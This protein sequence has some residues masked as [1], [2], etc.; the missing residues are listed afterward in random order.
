MMIC[1]P[2]SAQPNIWKLTMSGNYQYPI[3]EDGFVCQAGLFALG[4]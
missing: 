2:D 1:V 4:L 3:I